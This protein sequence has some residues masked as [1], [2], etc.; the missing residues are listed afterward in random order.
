MKIFCIGLNK[1]GTS[2][3]HQALE[4]LGYRGLHLGGP[5]VPIAIKRAADEGRGL[6]E[7]LGDYDA[8]SDIWRLSER[9]DVLDRQYPGSKF[10]LTIRDLD[11][12][13]DSR[14][15]HVER[16]VLRKSKGLYSGGFLTVDV[17]G[18]SGQY[19]EHH[20]RVFEYFADRPD[21]LLVM[22]V[23]GGD[24]YELLCPFLGATVPAERFP[25]DNRGADWRLKAG[26]TPAAAVGAATGSAGP[27][28]QDPESARSE[29]VFAASE[30]ARRSVRSAFRLSRRIVRGVARRGRLAVRRLHARAQRRTAAR[31][32]SRRSAA[33]VAYRPAPQR[34]ETRVAARDLDIDAVLGHLE[35]LTKRPRV[36][37]IVPI[38]NAYEDLRRCL[39]SLERT[40]TIRDADVLLVDDSSTDP[41]ILDLLDEWEGLDAVRVLRNK[42]NLG[43]TRTVNRGIGE[44]SGDVVLLN[45]D[46]EVTPRWLQNLV[47]CAYRDAK[48]ATV[49]AVSDNAGAFSVPQIGIANDRPHQLSSDEIG[50]LV[51]RTSQRVAPATPTGNGFC[52]YI[53][54]TALAD[55]GMFDAETFPR[56]YGEEGDFC[57]RARDAGWVNVVDDA[58]IVFHRRSA[59]FGSEK[60]EL[61]RVGRTQLDARHPDYTRLIREFVRSEPLKSV[62][63]KVRAAYAESASL[64][65]RIRSRILYVHHRGTGGT[66]ETNADLMGAILDDYEPY[67]L[68]SDT[69]TLELSRIEPD[70]AEPVERWSLPERL[71]PERFTE[72]AYRATVADLLVRHSIDLVHIRVLL[73]HTFDLPSVA[74]ALDIPVVLSFHDYFLVCPTF[75]LLDEAD[76]FCGGTC[77]PGEGECRIPSAWVKGV[78]HLKHS[79]VNVWQQSVARMLE[80]CDAFVTTSPTA[81]AIYLQTY[82]Q[83]ADTPFHVIEHGRDLAFEPLDAMPDLRGRVRIAIP[84]AF[85]VHKGAPFIERLLALDTAGRLEFHF[86]GK[87]P[88]EHRHLGVVHGSYQRHQFAQKMREIQPAFVGILSIW[89]ETYS[90]TLS[91]AW[92]AGLPVLVTDLGAPRERVERHGGGWILDHADPAG[93]YARILE[94]CADEAEYRRARSET[95]TAGIRTVRAMADDYDRLYRTTFLNRR[96]M[97]RPESSRGAR[98][99][100]AALFVVPG[101]NGNH[102]PTA[103]VRLLRRLDHPVVREELVA[104]VVTVESFVEGGVDDPDVAIVQRNAIAPEVIEAFLERI[105]TRAIP[106]VVDIDDDLLSIDPTHGSYAEYQSHIR[107]LAD[108]VGAADLI[109]VSTEHLRDAIRGRARRVAV[110][111]NMLDEFLWFG[112]SRAPAPTIAPARWSKQSIGRIA[113]QSIR[114]VRSRAATWTVRAAPTACNLVYVGSRTHAEDL[115]MLRPVVERLRERRDIDIRLFVIGGEPD[116]SMG[117]RWYKRV[118][119]PGGFSRYP[120]F[121]SW[122]RSRSRSWHVGVAPLRDTPFNRCKSDLKFL[123]YA[124][125][126]LPGIFSDV[127]PYRR[128]VTDAETGLLVPNDDEAWSSAILRLADDADLRMRIAGAAR[129][130][131]VNERCLRH[132]AADYVTLLGRVRA[133]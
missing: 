93:S 23:A 21:D 41:R 77:T 22:N 17:A 95:G 18:W 109:T 81:R 107:P 76:R 58:T 29:R 125:L 115:A 113:K 66:P 6:V 75:H 49:T 92:A 54:R 84:G 42:A 26:T 2:S 79:W 43:Y 60:D 35:Q 50:R 90:H 10:I 120:A 116:R 38:H 24:G 37:V 61:M 106:L 83:M 51:T 131:V 70:G 110:V 55:V 112:R 40:T 89:A 133:L 72:P 74:R 46:C 8:F 87:V 128:T 16:N 34:M 7:Y 9:F 129:S 82:P 53:K 19:R 13:L 73:A 15:R 126:G 118:Y 124:A 39:A 130:L 69:N 111:P 44:C 104:D 80:H 45:S 101:T 105:A 78:P 97:R 20:A 3:L 127:V 98:L 64:T 86:L 114:G 103:H 47:E 27:R 57:M 4:T 96:T 123:E 28:G 99:R 32:S 25:W 117:D 52:M 5:D 100:R 121:V 108:L 122:L 59:S 30:A 63:E 102:P 91:E 85:D 33:T 68:T 65:R 71:R 119:I 1:T 11:D 31:R 62:Q 67:L 88:E 12:W 36:T 132:G 48:T 14:R 94:I 56:G